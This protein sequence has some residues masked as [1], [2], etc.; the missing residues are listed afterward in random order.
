DQGE[1]SAA[2]AL[3]GGARRREEDAVEQ[4]REVRDREDGRTE[5]RG[6]P[7]E[8]STAVGRVE[9]KLLHPEACGGGKAGEPQRED[10]GEQRERGMCAPQAPE[11]ADVL[12][13]GGVGDRAGHEEEPRLG[14]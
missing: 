14:E 8:V 4:A 13:A 2:G 10:E 5:G 12:R 9:E 11:R 3:V 7:A 6:D 1:G